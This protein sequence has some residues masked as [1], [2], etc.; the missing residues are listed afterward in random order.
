MNNRRRL[1][2]LV[3]FAGA[4]FLAACSKEST[5]TAA[6]PAP[7]PM[8]ARAPDVPAPAA[9]PTPSSAS[10]SPAAVSSAGLPLLQESDPAA[11]GLGYVSVSSRADGSKYKNHSAAQACGNCALFAGQAGEAQGPC[12]LF[13]GKQ[14]AAAGWC[15]AY[16]KKTG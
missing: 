14:V 5:T 16:A 12:P 7:A 9:A 3:P 15:S 1:L 8:P 10:T 11:V 6:T 13:A 2:T 4:S